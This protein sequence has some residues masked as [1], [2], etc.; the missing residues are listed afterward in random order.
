MVWPPKK[1]RKL[2]WCSARQAW[3]MPLPLGNF[4]SPVEAAVSSRLDG[5]FA[6]KIASSLAVYRGGVLGCCWRFG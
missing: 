1:S 5:P 6:L 4:T 3:E 2:R